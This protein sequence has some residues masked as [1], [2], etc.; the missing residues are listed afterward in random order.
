[1]NNKQMTHDFLQWMI[2][3]Y[4]VRIT[5]EKKEDARMFEHFF[6]DLAAQLERKEYDNEATDNCT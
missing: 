5:M 3:N 1:M 4:N 6:P 2:D